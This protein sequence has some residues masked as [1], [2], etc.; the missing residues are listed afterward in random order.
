[1]RYS[2]DDS[3]AKGTRRAQFYSMLGTRSIWHEGWKA[4][5]TH[6]RLGGWG[7]YTLDEWQLYHTDVDRSELHNL[8]AEQPEKL[9]EMIHLWFAEA[10][11]NGAFP[12]DDRTV[13]EITCALSVPSSRRHAMG[14]I[15][16]PGWRN[17]PEETGGEHPQPLLTPSAP[18]STSRPPAR[19]A[20]SSLTVRAFGGHSLYVKDDRLHYVY[21]FIGML[22]RRTT[23]PTPPWE[24]M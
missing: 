9:E 23:R 13:V 14:Y 16:Y 11:R 24:R 6:P 21:S 17:V 8:A 18:S 12:L 4:V 15:Y 19:R 10:G 20:C 5:T 3:S 7:E 22:E 1:M 2:L